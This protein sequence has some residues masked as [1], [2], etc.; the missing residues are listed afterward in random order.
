M[1][2]S[3]PKGFPVATLGDCM[4]AKY[5]CWQCELVLRNPLQ[6]YCGHR[7]CKDCMLYLVR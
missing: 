1:M 6:S 5:Q 2:A 4:N 3:A 7:L